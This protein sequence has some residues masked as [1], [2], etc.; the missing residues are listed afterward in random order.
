[1]SAADRCQDRLYPPRWRV[2]IDP[3]AVVEEQLG[4]VDIWASSVLTIMFSGDEPNVRA[5]RRFGAFMYGNGVGAS[6]AWKLYMAC[7][8][9]RGRWRKIADSEAWIVYAMGYV[10]LEIYSTVI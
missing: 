1:M 9:T 6:D 3:F 4:S 2:K 5:S 8:G 10:L 7:Q